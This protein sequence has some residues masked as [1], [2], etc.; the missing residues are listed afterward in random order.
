M[1]LEQMSMTIVDL[2]PGWG[3]GGGGGGD[4]QL[5]LIH[6]LYLLTIATTTLSRCTVILGDRSM[7][8][9]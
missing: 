9:E 5:F 7:Y 8:A 2:R 3:G 6:Y 1:S 4:L